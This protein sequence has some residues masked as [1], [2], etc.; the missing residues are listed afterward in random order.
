L[1]LVEESFPDFIDCYFEYDHPIKKVNAASYL[2]LK[3]F[4]GVYVDLDF[5]CLKSLDD[6]LFDRR[7]LF[8]TSHDHPDKH[9][10]C[11]SNALIASIPG[12]PFWAGIESDLRS[13]ANQ[14]ALWATG[15]HFLSDRV[16]RARKFLDPSDLPEIAL[17]EI[18]Y[19]FR[20]DDSVRDHARTAPLADLRNL[21][22]NSHAITFWTGSWIS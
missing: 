16:R 4:G 21:Y 11:V 12:H 3:R 9:P 2:I 8:G 18:L 15:S 22:P 19:P 17:R 14:E 1:E 6:L 7:L 10:D 5:A 13:N 20:W